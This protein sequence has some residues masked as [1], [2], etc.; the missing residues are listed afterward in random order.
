MGV[1]GRGSRW[2]SLVVN[3]TAVSPADC[4]KPM[5]GAPSTDQEVLWV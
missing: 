5:T 4:K 1:Q 3:R 2:S